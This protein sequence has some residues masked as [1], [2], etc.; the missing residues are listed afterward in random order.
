MGLER[1]SKEK[2]TIL[3]RKLLFLEVGQDLC[4]YGQLLECYYKLTARICDLEGMEEERRD[5]KR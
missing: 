4:L 2:K 1:Q 5:K 3:E